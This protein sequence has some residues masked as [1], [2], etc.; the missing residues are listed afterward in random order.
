MNIND[1]PSNPIL[2]KEIEDFLKINKI[3][4]PTS[5]GVELSEDDRIFAIEY[6]MKE[7]LKVLGL[8]FTH[9]SMQHVPHRL[10]CMFVCEKFWGLLPD[11]FPNI[12]IIKT[13]TCQPFTV[14]NVEILTYCDQHLMPIRGQAT[15]AYS[16]KNCK[17]K[18]YLP[19]ASIHRMVEYFCKRPQDIRNMTS[20]IEA[21]LRYI[22]KTEDVAVFV[23]AKYSCMRTKVLSTHRDS[24]NCIKTSGIF[25]DLSAIET[26]VF[27]RMLEKL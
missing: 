2:G 27:M 13:D 16:T 21:S 19:T 5:G 8:D 24:L 9:T 17:E 18:L 26:Q 15:I 1:A 20:Q 3:Q 7:A 22:L 23:N 10:S 11:N 14:E 6:Y 12:E 25:N 4:T